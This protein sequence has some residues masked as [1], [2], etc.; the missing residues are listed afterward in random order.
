[1]CT[2]RMH[3][4]LIVCVFYARISC[5]YMQLENA[6]LS[7]RSELSQAQAQLEEYKQK[8]VFVG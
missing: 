7:S 3:V 6:I 2:V 5:T 8:L 1:M 4:Y